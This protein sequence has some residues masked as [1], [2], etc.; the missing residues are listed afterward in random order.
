METIQCGQLRY[1]SSRC[2]TSSC[3][4]YL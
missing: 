3:Q 4:W 2:T 1:T